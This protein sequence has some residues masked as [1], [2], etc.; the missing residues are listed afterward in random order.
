MSFKKGE[1]GNPQGRPKGILD[2]RV[3]LRALLDPHKKELVAKAVERALDGDTQ[4][5]RLCLERLIPPIKSQDLPV[6]I[7]IPTG[8]LVE[9]AEAV[10]ALGASGDLSI[11]DLSTLM[12]MVSTMARIIDVDDLE[13]RITALEEQR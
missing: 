3:E 1:S 9:R 12:Q 6:E 13:R 8:T 10:L 11:S 4:A 7:Q 5:L 2:K